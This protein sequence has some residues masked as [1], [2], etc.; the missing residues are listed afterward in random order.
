MKVFLDA[1]ILFSAAD[2]KSAT[3]R[4]LN[5]IT[6]HGTAVTCPHAWE[7]ARRNLA[8]K[9]PQH[10]R[11]LD[12]LRARVEISLAFAEPADA[13]LPDCDVPIL[14]GARAS[15]CTHLWT[16]DRRHFGRYYG[17][18]IG[19]VQMVSSVMLADEVV[20]RGWKI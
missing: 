20:R 4:L 2:P 10:L 16:S 18:V 17:K 9:R 7:E 14:A 11:G 15:Q 5:T 8:L 12:L 3:R 1:N 13:G 6:Q 19:G